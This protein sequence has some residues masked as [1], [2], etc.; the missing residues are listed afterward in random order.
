MLG[1]STTIFLESP[2]AITPIPW[3]NNVPDFS[4]IT[5]PT[6]SVLVKAWNDFLATAE[7]LEIIPDPDPFVEPAIPDWDGLYTSLLDSQV[8]QH[9]VGLSLQF[10]PVNSALDKVITAINYG[11][12]KPDS[13]VAWDAFQSA[14]NLLVYAL[15]LAGQSLSPDHLAEIRTAL[16]N[17]G[18]EGIIL[19]DN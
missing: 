6:L 17:N 3:V 4:G 1:N 8:Y 14:V 19:V 18:F 10:T 2:G 16:N 15:G 5:E 13:T 7:E 9:L 11:D 12:K